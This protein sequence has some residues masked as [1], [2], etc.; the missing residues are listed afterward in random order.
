M[1]FPFLLP[2]WNDAIIRPLT[3]DRGRLHLAYRHLPIRR[4]RT[5][6]LSSFFFL[7]RGS[8]GN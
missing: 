6:L 7:I 8:W 1:I 4:Y 3:M 2:R 5:L